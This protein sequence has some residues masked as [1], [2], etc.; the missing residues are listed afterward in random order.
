[1]KCTAF[2]PML[3]VATAISAFPQAQSLSQGPHKMELTLERRT[4]NNWKIVDPGY[5]FSTGD[6]VR[7][8]VKTNF[9]GYL[10][11]MNQGTAGTYTKLFPRQDTGLAN[12]VE[13]GKE[14]VVPATE[15]AFRVEG[16]PGHD[17]IF[18]M[19]MPVEMG[20]EKNPYKPLPPPPPPSSKASASLTPR[21]DDTVL[22]ARGDCVDSSAGP[23]ATEA[24]KL[25]ENLKTYAQNNPQELIFRKN[26]NRSVVSSPVPL[27]GPVIYEF[28]LAHK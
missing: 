18:W 5:I 8:R 9:T 10:Y 7:F 26:Q 3:A 16:P 24:K 28:R 13:A 6:Q 15:G 11:V 2:L 1:M 12:R 14:Y 25:P 22:R 23:H 27:T 17:V 19:I 4:N 20:G 21:C